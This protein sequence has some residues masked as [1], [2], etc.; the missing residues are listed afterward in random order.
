MERTLIDRQELSKRWGLTT[1]TIIKYEECGL[2]TRNPNFEKPLYYL[3]EIQNIDNY[4]PNPL[5]HF[6]RKRLENENKELKD[7]INALESILSKVVMVGTESMNI[8][9]NLKV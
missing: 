9:T 2:I 7:R 8:L 5:S 1:R 4:K 3:E 6:E